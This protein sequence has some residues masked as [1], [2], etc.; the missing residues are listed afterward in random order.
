MGRD[1]DEDGDRGGVR[2][3]RPR[4]LGGPGR[5]RGCLNVTAERLSLGAV[6]RGH[7]VTPP[8]VAALGPRQSPPKPP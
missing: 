8:V 1:G 5:G 3:P 2:A 6:T 4:R 7:A